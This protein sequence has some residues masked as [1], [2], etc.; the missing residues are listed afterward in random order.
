MGI[1]ILIKKDT[2]ATFKS[3]KVRANAFRFIKL[4]EFNP[5]YI[6]MLVT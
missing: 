4:S 5:T 3:E 6:V 1:I 2:K